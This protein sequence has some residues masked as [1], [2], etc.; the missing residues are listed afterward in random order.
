[1]QDKNNEDVDAD[2]LFGNLRSPK[3]GKKGSVIDVAPNKASQ[4][5]EATSRL[6]KNVVERSGLPRVDLSEE[7]QQDRKVNSY[8][9]QTNKPVDVSTSVRHKQQSSVSDK[10]TETSTPSDTAS[11]TKSADE[12]SASKPERRNRGSKRNPDYVSKKDAKRIAEDLFFA[13][14]DRVRTPL[15]ERPNIQLARAGNFIYDRSTN[16][17]FYDDP[18]GDEQSVKVPEYLAHRIADFVHDKTGIV[19]TVTM[20]DTAK[21]K[22]SN[23]II[24]E[25]LSLDKYPM[26]KDKVKERYDEVRGV[27]PFSD[28]NTRYAV[29]QKHKQLIR[30]SKFSEKTKKELSDYRFGERT[31]E[32]IDK[33]NAKAKFD[34]EKREQTAN[35]IEAFKKGNETLAGVLSRNLNEK[36]YEDVISHAI[37]DPYIPYDGAGGLKY[38][39]PDV[40]V[41]KPIQLAKDIV[42][43]TKKGLTKA[44]LQQLEKEFDNLPKNYQDAVNKKLRSAMTG[45]GDR[46]IKDT[47]DAINGKVNNQVPA[48]EKENRIN[49]AIDNAVATEDERV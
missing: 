1:M 32:T 49:S 37:N 43:G 20:I 17:L 13:V 6:R 10:G 24:D 48:F 28:E 44:K 8:G 31:G 14:D 2:D 42:T 15:L 12:T 29:E 11:P 4:I 33:N 25:F 16:T 22:T 40:E 21:D 39:A 35:T 26:H 47:Y 23:Q 18:L 45:M 46:Y 41:A 36:Q 5:K 27:I 9:D 38:Q 34:A 7:N 30:E 19:G 3:P